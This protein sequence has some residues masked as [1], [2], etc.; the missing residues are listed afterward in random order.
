[1]NKNN[2]QVLFRLDSNRDSKSEISC[3]PKIPNF[4]RSKM[5]IDII[6]IITFMV[7]LASARSLAVVVVIVR[8]IYYDNNNI[9]TANSLDSSLT[10]NFQLF[11]AVLLF[12]R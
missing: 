8:E 7:P 6:I 2:F 4:E 11:K 3:L 1:M 9:F 10:S 12:V 5:Y